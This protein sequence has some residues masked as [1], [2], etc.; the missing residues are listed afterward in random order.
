MACAD[1]FTKDEAL[2]DWRCVDL[3]A[4]GYSPSTIFDGLLFLAVL[5][6]YETAGAVWSTHSH[7]THQLS[8]IAL[9]H[10]SNL[11]LEHV[12]TGLTAASIGSDSCRHN[13]APQVETW[14]ARY[15]SPLGWAQ[16]C[17]L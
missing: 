17:T 8:A 4:A 11:A 10:C 7:L 2:A 3:S 15:S 9:H 16:P 6:S 13:A 14:P 12:M 1:V 5:H